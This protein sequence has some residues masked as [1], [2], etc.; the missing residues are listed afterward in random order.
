[1][2]EIVRICLMC[3]ACENWRIP[4]LHWVCKAFVTL[5]S[6]RATAIQS[7]K[8]GKTLPSEKNFTSSLHM[9]SQ[10]LAEDSYL[11]D[12]CTHSVE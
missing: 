4:L 7:L 10:F 6:L 12:L 5:K 11:I 3:T 8:G 1:M 2:P 9:F